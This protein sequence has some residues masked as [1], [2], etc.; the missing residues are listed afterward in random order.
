MT[1]SHEPMLPSAV[2]G[3]ITDQHQALEAMFDE[4]SRVS[5][6]L[7]QG[8]PVELAQAIELSLGL[9]E[10]LLL[11]IT[12][13]RELLVPALRDADAWGGA[14]AQELTRRLV[15]RRS[16]IAA[17]RESCRTARLASFG[18]A[19]DQFIDGCQASIVLAVLTDLSALRDDVVAIDCQDG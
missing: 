10:L 2:S 18:G 3:I 8:G 13:E 19:I 12:V 16:A 17:L 5:G 6:L 15:E 14:R 7:E 4:L 9:C 11:H 1:L